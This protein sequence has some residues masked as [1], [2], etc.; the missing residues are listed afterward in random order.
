[1]FNQSTFWKTF[2]DVATIWRAFQTKPKLEIWDVRTFMQL[3][4]ACAAALTGNSAGVAEKLAIYA[5][6]EGE[7]NAFNKEYLLNP[8]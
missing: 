8:W 4:Q 6:G 5:Q 1:M 7:Y 3:N 2:E